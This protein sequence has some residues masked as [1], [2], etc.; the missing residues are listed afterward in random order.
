MDF[1]AS[2]MLN[3]SL[4]V[5]CHAHVVQ[6]DRSPHG[7]LDENCLHL[8]QLA[9]MAVDYP[10]TGVVAT[11]PFHLR[12]KLYPDFLQ[13]D[14]KITYQ[15]EKII[16]ILYRKVSKIVKKEVE[17]LEQASHYPKLKSMYDTD[18]QVTGYEAY[19]E[20]A[21]ATKVLYDQHLLGL[22][23]HFNV[24][25]EADVV[26]G[27]VAIRKSSL[28]HGDLKDRIK[29]AYK[30]LR[31]DFHAIFDP[32]KLEK[33]ALSPY[34][35]ASSNPLTREE[36]VETSAMPEESINFAAKASAWYHVTYHPDWIQ[37]ALELRALELRDVAEDDSETI[38]ASPLLSFA[39][40]PADVLAKIK[41]SKLR[42]PR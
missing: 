22:M 38:S 36:V 19:L 30:S 16:G 34:S 31:N 3:D 10:K 21:W 20:D 42:E 7:A 6:A 27:C 41:I 14:K 4:G 5:I 40:L 33:P 39:W 25:R 29:A 9:A 13:K 37:R 26:T 11:L 23:G 24:K 15:S 28:Q 12:P 17:Q 35:S 8:A 1:F 2:S 32:T 18:L